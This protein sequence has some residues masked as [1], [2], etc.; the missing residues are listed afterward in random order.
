VVSHFSNELQL[1]WLLLHDFFGY[2]GK[3]KEKERTTNRKQ[4]EGKTDREHA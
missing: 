2:K 1:W 3:L 4:K